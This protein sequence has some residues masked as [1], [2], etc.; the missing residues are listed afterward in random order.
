MFDLEKFEEKEIEKKEKVRSYLPSIF[1]M[2]SLP[3]RDVKK[4]K[5]VRKYN[6]VELTL[7]SPESVP[8]GQY[9]RIVLSLFTTYAVVNKSNDNEVILSFDSLREL[10]KELRLPEQRGKEILKVLKNF[11]GTTLLFQEKRKKIVQKEL[12][13]EYFEEKEGEATVYKYD[14]GVINFVKK[15]SYYELE[16]SSGKENRKNVG[17]R[18]E[19]DNGFVKLCEE[20]SVPIDYTVYKDIT[21]PLGKDL[22]AWI[23]YRNNYLTDESLFISRKLLVEQFNPVNP[24]S[25]DK[26]AQERVNYSRIKEQLNIIKRDHY[27]DLKCEILKDGSGIILYKSKAVMK[28]EDKRYVLITN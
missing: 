15:M 2:A 3:L 19:L 26:D 16:D 10:T 14:T 13:S 12:F 6:N 22:Y 24:E 4:T 11:V 25:K 27:K 5:F 7:N 8:C 23:V 17:I 1:I 9:G 18:I 20:H 28:M 21:S